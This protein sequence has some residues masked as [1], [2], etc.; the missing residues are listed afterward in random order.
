[1]IILCVK[2]KSTYFFGQYKE[3]ANTSLVNGWYICYTRTNIDI[4]CITYTELGLPVT[5][6]EYKH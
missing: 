4:R 6:V 2:H 1:M 5:C 3:R